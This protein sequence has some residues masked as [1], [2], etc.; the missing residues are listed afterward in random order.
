MDLPAAHFLLRHM[1]AAPAWEAMYLHG[2]LH[3]IEG[4]LNNARAWYGD[5][6]ESEV[7]RSVWSGTESG[8]DDA[9]N[10]TTSPEAAFQ[11]AK[12]FLDRVEAY[13]NSLLSTKSS[14]GATSSEKYFPGEDELAEVSLWEIRRLLSFCEEKFD[15]NPVMDASNVWVSMNE[16]HAD[17]AVQMITGG[18]G[19]REF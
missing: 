14:S 17:K 7:F 6:K 12:S 18:E 5:V 19:W 9:S 3:R 13:K 10:Q 1:Q 2:L 8:G 11:T 16:K 4:D 15:T